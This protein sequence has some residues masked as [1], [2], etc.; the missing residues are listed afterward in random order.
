MIMFLTGHGGISDS[1]A[2][3]VKCLVSMGSLGQQERLNS[4]E[5]LSPMSLKAA[6]RE[7]LICTINQENL[8][9]GLNT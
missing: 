8:V 6:G 1:T 9:S 4:E 7:D 2:I 5:N 3:S